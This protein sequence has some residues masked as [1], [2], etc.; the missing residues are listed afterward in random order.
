MKKSYR[1]LEELCS[2]STLTIQQFLNEHRSNF[3]LEHLLASLTQ[4]QSALKGVGTFLMKNFN[5]IHFI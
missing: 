1:I 4:S 3:L 2:R 5:S